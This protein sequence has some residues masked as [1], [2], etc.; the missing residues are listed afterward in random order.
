MTRVIVHRI[1]D[2]PHPRGMVHVSTSDGPK[3]ID[4][5]A[6]KYDAAGNRLHPYGRVY[7]GHAYRTSGGLTQSDLREN[8]HGKIVS[9][10]KSAIGKSL[11][12]S[13]SSSEKATIKKDLARG[14]RIRGIRSRSKSGRRSRSKST[15]R[16]H[17]RLGGFNLGGS[18][19]GS[20]SDSGSGYSDSD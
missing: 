8:K 13:L 1:L 10:A 19:S 14:R 12:A 17:L 11:Y 20:D 2:K 5:V 6:E 18:G 3:C 16:S 15:S 4:R 7:N 9:K